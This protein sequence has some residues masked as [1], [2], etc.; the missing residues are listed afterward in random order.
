MVV[1]KNRFL[2]KTRVEIGGFFE[3]KPEEVF[4]DMREPNM[5]ELAQLQ[6]GW[7]ECAGKKGKAILVLSSYLSSFIF[8]HNIFHDDGKKYTSEEVTELICDRTKLYKHVLAQYYEKVLFTIMP[9]TTQEGQSGE[10]QSE[11]SET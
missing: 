4:I 2:I 5:T 7:A 3:A 8:D 9:Q 6:E 11:H 1:E 10:D